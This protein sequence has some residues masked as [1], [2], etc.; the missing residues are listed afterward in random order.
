MSRGEFLTEAWTAVA[1]PL[2]SVSTRSAFWPVLDHSP[3]RFSAPLTP[4]ATPTPAAPP[5]PPDAANAEMIAV[6]SDEPAAVT[7]RPP[8]PVVVMR[9]ASTVA[10]TE[11]RIRFEA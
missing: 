11:P 5:P 4:S 1:P 2:P 7:V 6:I 9:L 10:L 8:L 3:M